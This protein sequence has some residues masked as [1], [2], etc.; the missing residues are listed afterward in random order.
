[1]H[2]Q[3]VHAKNVKKVENRSNEFLKNVE[4]EEIIQDHTI[5]LYACEYCEYKTAQKSSKGYI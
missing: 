3:K 4:Y 2:I 5:N 1:M